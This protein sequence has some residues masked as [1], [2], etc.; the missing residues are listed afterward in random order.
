LLTAVFL[1]SFQSIAEREMQDEHG[2]WSRRFRL[3]D[4]PVFLA[5]ARHQRLD[6]AAGR[7]GLSYTTISR[8]VASLERAIGAKLFE[9]TPEGWI[10]TGVG[11]RFYDKALEVEAA[12]SDAFEVCNSRSS[13]VHGSVRLVTTE[14]FGVA[15][16][17]RWLSDFLVRYPD[18]SLELASSARKIEFRQFDI[19]VA[20]HIPDIERVKRRKLADYSLGLY[21]SYE[22]LERM[23]IPKSRSEISG[24][25][26]VWFVESSQDFGELNC[27]R[28]ILP[29]P[30]IVFQATSVLCQISAVLAGAGVGLLPRF[31]A[32][33]EPSLVALLPG[34]VDIRRRYWLVVPE[35][36]YRRP[37]VQ[38]SA[39]FLLEKARELEQESSPQGPG[40]RLNGAP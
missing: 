21:A 15:A 37:A 23:G 25:Q 27:L 5:L 36:S 26:F 12:A 39:S 16:A 6:P 2:T 7:L 20:V 13:E 11:V 4:I 3:D 31:L 30:R 22:Y 17:S 10:L 40:P 24:H 14:G 38:A 9:R 28:P 18:I 8:R 32:N 34:E 1:R 29:N 35:D 19:A 33:S